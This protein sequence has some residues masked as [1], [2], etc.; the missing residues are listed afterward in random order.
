MRPSKTHYRVIRE[1]SACGAD[2]ITTPDA[3]KV[4]CKTCLRRMP[5]G[6][7]PPMRPTVSSEVAMRAI[8]LRSSVLEA[9]LQVVAATINRCDAKFN[10]GPGTFEMY[11]ELRQ[12]VIELLKIMGV[13]V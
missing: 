10:T 5:L 2:G 3:N 7:V 6:N 11:N 9:S 1:T 8:L 13:E 12:E 4:T